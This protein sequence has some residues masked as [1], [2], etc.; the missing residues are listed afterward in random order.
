MSPTLLRAWAMDEAR[1]GNITYH[2]LDGGGPMVLR[3]WASETDER[4]LTFD[5]LSAVTDLLEEGELKPSRRVG[6]PTGGQPEEALSG[7]LID[8]RKRE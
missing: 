5:E 1:S 4:E 3:F 2:R 8:A 7:I 6:K